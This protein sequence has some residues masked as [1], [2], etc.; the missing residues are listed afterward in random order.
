MG[1][2][3]VARLMI[4]NLESQELMHRIKR[5]LII[6]DYRKTRAAWSLGKTP[7]Q[8]IPQLAHRCRSGRVRSMYEHWRSEVTVSKHSGNMPEM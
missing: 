7:M 1:Y 4:L 3:A 8:L 6:C 2:L 5:E